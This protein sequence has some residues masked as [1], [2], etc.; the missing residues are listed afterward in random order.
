LQAQDTAESVGLPQLGAAEMEC[1]LKIDSMLRETHSHC[2]R[3]QLLAGPENRIQCHLVGTT[4]ALQ[5]F[6]DLSASFGGK[7]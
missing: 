7:Q 5:H 1:V 2:M 3:L 4:V 6:D